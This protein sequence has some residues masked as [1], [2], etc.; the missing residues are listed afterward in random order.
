M[1]EGGGGRVTANHPQEIL[2]Y[3]NALIAE[4]DEG[5]VRQAIIEA[6][7][8]LTDGYVGAESIEM[9]IITTTTTSR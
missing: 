9:K 7:R 2:A 6:P 5:Q 4:C 8:E 3:A 1:D